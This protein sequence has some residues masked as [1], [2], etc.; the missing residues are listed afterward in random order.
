MEL[1]E[2]LAWLGAEATEAD[3]QALE[4]YGIPADGAFGVPMGKMLAW[5]RGRPRDHA[6]AAGLWSDG[7]YEARTLAV[8]IEDPALV[9]PGQMDAWTEGFDSWAI[10]DTACFR[11]FDRT[12]FAWAKVTAYAAREEEFVRRTAFALTWALSVHDKAAP[13]KSFVDALALCETHATD[14]RPSVRKA[15]SM[16]LRATGKRNRALNAA[17]RAIAARLAEGPRPAAITGREAL[18]DLSAPALLAR[19]DRQ[20]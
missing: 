8:L 2:A 20:A 14:D 3:R 17:A 16:A 12:P 10:C 19:L 7:R 1:S 15:V 11:L 9:T 4:R 5:A 13:D 18:K 6:L